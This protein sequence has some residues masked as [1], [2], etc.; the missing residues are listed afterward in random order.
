MKKHLPNIITLARI[1]G[2]MSLLFTD[3]STDMMSPFW[4]IY[5]FCGITDMIDGFLARKLHAESKQGAMFD[6]VADLCFV[7][8]CAW[9]LFPN[10]NLEKWM[11]IWIAI[12]AL[13]K[14]INL[15]SALVVHGKFVFPHTIANKYTGLLLFISIPIYVCLAFDILINV[16]VIIATFAA[17]QEGHYIRTKQKIY[18]NR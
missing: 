7:G 15:I 14:I 3:V 5:L 18:E 17:I 9:K 1:I 8:M 2:A 13:I 10:L 4:I 12:I 11:W 6:S 16:T